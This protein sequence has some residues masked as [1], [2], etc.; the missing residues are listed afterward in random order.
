MLTLEQRIFQQEELILSGTDGQPSWNFSSAC[1]WQG[2]DFLTTVQVLSTLYAS[3]KTAATFFKMFLV[4]RDADHD[5]LLR[6]LNAMRH[7]T[8]RARKSAG[9]TLPVLYSRLSEIG[10]AEKKIEYIR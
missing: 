7:G 5:D 2:P 10:R 8:G 4:M 6:E 3:H 9:K 1:V